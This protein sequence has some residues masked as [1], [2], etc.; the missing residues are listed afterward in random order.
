MNFL[1]VA[2]GGACGSVGRYWLSVTIARAAG[3]VFPW[4]TLIVNI[5]GC[6]FIGWFA[7][8][9]GPESRYALNP[10]ARIFVMTGICGGFTTFSSFSLEALNLARSGE[11]MRAGAYVLAS[12]TACLVGVFLG[13]LAGA[14][15]P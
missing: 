15:R 6:C 5:I 12:V 4:G 7:S 2:I 13:Y 9:Y 3:G 10:S 14:N 1:W 8:S 11:W